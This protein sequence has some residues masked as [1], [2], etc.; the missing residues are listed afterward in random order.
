M[1]QKFGGRFSPEDTR[2]EARNT[3]P[4]ASARASRAAPP[5]EPRIT[6]KWR[7][8]VLYL[9]ALTFLFPAFRGTPREMLMGLAAGG[10]ILLATWLTREGLR[11]HAAYDARKVARRPAF[12]RKL[13]AAVIMGAA[14][15][16]GGLIADTGLVY[17]VL[18][19]LV[20]AGLHLL[21]FGPD[22]MADKGMEGI[23]V[24]QTDRVARAVDEGEKH[25]VAMKDAI[26][27]AKDRQLAARVDRFVAAA[28]NLFRIVENDPGDL[29]AA[30]KYL[31][32]YL[33]GARDA[34]IK[35]ADI[36]A[37]NR[38]AKARADYEALLGD[39]ETTFARR[40]T[41]LLKSSHSDLDVEIAVLRDRLKLET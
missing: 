11:A 9:S 1:A 7:L 23:D 32:V 4:A 19:G 38:D 40:T 17:P 16:L 18:F 12:P 13:A 30:R 35:F 14:L 22:P 41:E 5:A 31:S 33:M 26:L 8:T 24:F 36:Y 39:L 29:T 27:R 21:A 6:G 28:R 25:L 10:L 20:G 37:R 3:D 15:T 2:P 34:T